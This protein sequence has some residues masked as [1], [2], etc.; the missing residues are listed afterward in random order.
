MLA[1]SRLLILALS[2]LL[3]TTTHAQ[4]TQSLV[5]SLAS[6]LQAATSQPA[7]TIYLRT[8]KDIYVAGEDCWFNAFV[9]DGHTATL[10][11]LDKILFVQLVNPQN[12][13]IVWKEIYPIENGI[14]G[15]HVFLPHTLPPGP[16]LF[17]AYSAHSFYTHQPNFTAATPI[18][19]VNDPRAIKRIGRLAATAPYA[20]GRPINWQ[21]SPTGGQLIAGI[22]NT[23]AFR[24][25]N[26]QG[27]PISVQ[28][29]LFRNDVALQTIQSGHAGIGHFDLTPQS[30]ASYR[31]VLGGG[32]DTMFH[33][34]AVKTAGIQLQINTQPDSLL[35]NIQAAQLPAQTVLIS[36]HARGELQAIAA[37]KLLDSLLVR[38]PQADLPPGV[39]VVT[40]YNEQLQPLCSQPVFIQPQRLQVSFSE[41]KP[42]YGAK[43]MVTVRIK[44]TDASGQPVP[45]MLSLRVHDQLFADRKNAQDLRTHYTLSTQLYETLYD[46]AWYFDNLPDKRTEAVNLLLQL[47]APPRLPLAAS[48][49]VVSDSLAATILPAAKQA[50]PQGPVS[51][52]VFNY[53]KTQSQLIASDSKGQFYLTPDLLATGRRFFV[54][55][56]AEKEHTFS[57][58]DPFSLIHLAESKHKAPFCAAVLT[59]DATDKPVTDTGTF[60]YGHLLEEVVVK[61]KG[62]GYGDRFLGYLDSIA[63][64]EGNTDFVGQCGWLNCPACGSGTKPKEG[65][66]YTE[67]TDKKRNEVTSHPFSFG[68]G[69]TRQVVYKYP[70]YTEA[71]LLKKFKMVMTR[72]F[73]QD[74][75][76]QSPDYALED[77]SANDMRNSLY[78]SPLIVTN[79]Q[80]EATIHF[81]TSDIR[82]S[83]IGVVEG[84][85]GHGALGVGRFNFSVL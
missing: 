76:Y 26:A 78:W 75:L 19:V 52:L 12:D 47:A 16:F 83:F 50:K 71:E 54:K 42:Q 10:S 49:P 68:Q 1:M 32:P 30:G 4:R 14:S 8:H 74:R 51:L 44:T 58:T 29:M 61:A 11:S 46:P 63:K 82:S 24:A 62:R 35:C 55:Y 59:V 60:Q 15:G 23:V 40:V 65:V 33:L 81:Y 84:V 66:R 25:T 22:R 28:G 48:H 72:G 53:N 6:R 3:F 77:K 2:L 85:S 64:F 7:T 43:E 39:A 17:K 34:P 41:I 36:L 13:S 5:D 45:A 37:G 21:L 9:L 57:I 73:Y 38:F 69:D 18:Q 70:T 27:V 56:L 80:G 20:K 67:L 31:I 79:E